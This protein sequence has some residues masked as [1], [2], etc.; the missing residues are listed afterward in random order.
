MTALIASIAILAQ[1][2]APVDQPTAVIGQPA[3]T[4][5]VPAAD[6]KT[7][8]LKSYE[9]KFVVLE[10]TNKGCHFV[11]DHYGSGH[12]QSLQRLAKEKGVVWLT[13]CTS[14]VG[15]QGYLTAGEHVEHVK[16]VK[17]EPV[18]V[19]LDTDGKVGRAYG[20]KTTPQMVLIDPKGTL[21]Y[22]GAI[23]DAPK[24]DPSKAKNYLKL[25]MEEALAGKPVTTTTTRP[26]GCSVKY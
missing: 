16:A 8:D 2:Q 20:A 7:Y 18:A 17:A 23:D 9:G 13:I 25:A 21:L 24:G 3:P 10:W 15:K 14:G 19:L 26:Y 4:F 11:Q 1:P 22:N 12:M 6:G 5:S